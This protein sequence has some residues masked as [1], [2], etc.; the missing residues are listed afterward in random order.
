MSSQLSGILKFLMDMSVRMLYPILGTF[1]SLLLRNL[2]YV[3]QEE[4]LLQA[5]GW[6]K[7]EITSLIMDWVGGCITQME[8]RLT[9]GEKSKSNHPWYTGSGNVR[10]WVFY[11]LMGNEVLFAFFLGASSYAGRNF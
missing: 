3:Q 11:R 9:R 6:L 1:G 4:I 2:L 5:T 7:Q 8:G 10:C